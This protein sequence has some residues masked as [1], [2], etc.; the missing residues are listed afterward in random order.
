LLFFSNHFSGF[1]VLEG[2]ERAWRIKPIPHK[3][4]TMAVALGSI[5]FKKP[6]ESVD[7]KKKTK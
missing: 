5:F 1:K 4:K 3:A 7:S 6:V 2:N